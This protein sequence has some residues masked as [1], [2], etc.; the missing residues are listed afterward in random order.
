MKHIHLFLIIII[1]FSSC[2]STSNPKK[3]E[4]GTISKIDVHSHYQHSRSYL[5]SFLKKWNMRS[6]LVDVAKE[7]PEGVE[8]SW[9]HY[10]NHATTQ[11]DLYFLCSSLIGTGID[12]PDFATN[13]I[14]LLEEE[15]NSG[16]RMVKVWKNFW[17]G[18]TRR[19]R[20]FHSN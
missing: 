13:A 10:Q 18:Y 4:I 3:I 11:P 5:P 7:G 8:R 17:D 15:I 1:S 19:I 6:V 9:G 2:Q 20:K 16:A 14:T 12:A